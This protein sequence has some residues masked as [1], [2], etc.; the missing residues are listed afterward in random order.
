[1]PLMSFWLLQAAGDLDDLATII[2]KN[3]W[4]TDSNAHIE[5]D[6]SP[7]SF[8]YYETHH[9]CT[10]LVKIAP[11]KGDIYFSQDTW[12]TYLDLH[13]VTK[14]YDFPIKKSGNNVGFDAAIRRW[15][16]SSSPGVMV[17]LDDLWLLDN[18]L[19]VLETT[20]NNCT[21]TILLI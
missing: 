17:S 3:L 20:M 10:G 16:I 4:K 5:A 12:S 6:L 1:M 15:T 14:Y 9:H 18:G 7:H 21:I 2:T 11:D 13:R 19:F 8:E